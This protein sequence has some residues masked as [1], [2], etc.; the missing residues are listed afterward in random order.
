MKEIDSLL[1]KR[2]VSVAGGGIVQELRQAPC[3]PCCRA[4]APLSG[5]FRALPR[6]MVDRLSQRCLDHGD[7]REKFVDPV[8]RECPDGE[9]LDRA[10]K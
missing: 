7:M 6:V 8:T 10:M 4:L 5:D 2:K 3:D 9:V 1:E